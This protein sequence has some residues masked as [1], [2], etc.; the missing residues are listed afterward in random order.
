MKYLIYIIM[1]VATLTACSNVDEDDR[2]VYVKPAEVAK[3]VLIEDFTGQRCVNCPLATETIDSLR[4]IYGEE[5]VIAVGIHS[6]PFAK[7]PAGTATYP[8]Y[9]ETGDYYYNAFGVS[10]QPS[11]M[12]DRHGVVSNYNLWPTL[13]YEYIQQDAP[14]MLSAETTYDE[15]ARE[16]EITVVAEGVEPTTGYLQVWVT[17]DSITA[18]QYM[19]DGSINRSYVHNHVFRATVNDR[20][21]DAFEIGTDEIVTATYNYTLEDDE[22]V[23]Q[24]MHVVAFVYNDDGVAQAV[25]TQITE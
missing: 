9:T 3:R 19:P 6:G 10:S 8:L 18:T 4:A 5:N 20:D 17:E 11:G 16:V 15:Q 7:N 22:W 25:T 1:C 14:I 21:G 23:A 24:N 2:Y 12:I 13:V